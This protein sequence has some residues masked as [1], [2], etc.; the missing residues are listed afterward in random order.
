[1]SVTL[2]TPHTGEPLLVRFY[3]PSTLT[4]WVHCFLSSPN[5]LLEWHVI[6]QPCL[7][8]KMYCLKLFSAHLWVLPRWWRDSQAPMHETR[9]CP[10]HLLTE[11]SHSEMLVSHPAEWGQHKDLQKKEWHVGWKAQGM[12]A[13]RVVLRPLTPLSSGKRSSWAGGSLVMCA[14]K[15]LA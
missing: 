1:M 10:T 13:G 11:H 9:G 3:T 7:L 8:E 2:N 5:M 12:S 14:V 4:P 6:S 15:E